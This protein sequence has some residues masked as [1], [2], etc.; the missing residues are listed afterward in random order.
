MEKITIGGI[1]AILWGKPSEKVYLWVHGK[2]SCKEQAEDFARIAEVRGYQT[3]SF[4]LPEHGDRKGEPDRCDIFNG[5][6]D[7][8]VVG[9]YVFAHWK[10]VSLYGCSLGA[11]F[12]LHAYRDKPFERCLFQSP[13]LNMEY[14]VEQM[15]LWFDVTPRQLE[16]AG[17]IDTPVDPLRWDYFQYVRAHPITCW[18][19]PTHILY[20]G[21]DTLQS[22]PVVRAFAEK[23]DCSLTISPNSDHP[24]GGEKDGEIVKLWLEKNV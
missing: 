1:P 9:A 20:G 14:L 6:W 8:R 18:T 10:K 17:E 15:M 24:F 13:I 5:I 22:E 19:S 21:R 7:L 3:L 4:D 16:Q 2:M 11:F 23:F 12:A